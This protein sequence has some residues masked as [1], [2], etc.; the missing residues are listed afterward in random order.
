MREELSDFLLDPVGKH[1]TKESR[2]TL[3]FLA[4]F[5]A[6]TSAFSGGSKCPE[7]G[8]P[9]HEVTQWVKGRLRPRPQAADLLTPPQESSLSFQT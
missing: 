8:R 2:M 5:H 3:K 6:L 4:P 1:E 7:R 9:L